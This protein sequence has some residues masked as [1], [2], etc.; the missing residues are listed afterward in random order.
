M[1]PT[2]CDRLLLA[3]IYA[4]DHWIVPALTA[5]CERTALLSLDEARGMNIEDVVLVVSVRE[6]IRS[7]AIQS[8]VSAAEISR[9]VEAK[10]PG[11]LIPATGNEVPPASPTSVAAEQ[12]PDSTVDA[13]ISPG[14]EVRNS[15]DPTK[16]KKS[17][18][19]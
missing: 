2:S 6:D 14:L 8:G 11:V 18:R 7:K 17:T 16:R 10:Q 3:R 4:V 9:R 19:W 5:L 15:M 13:T 12:R 1:P